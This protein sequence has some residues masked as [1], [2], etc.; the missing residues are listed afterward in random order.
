MALYSDLVTTDC[1]RYLQ[2]R[3]PVEYDFYTDFE[4]QTLKLSVNSLFIIIC[5]IDPGMSLL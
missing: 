5:N 3:P 2:V 1:S 4:C